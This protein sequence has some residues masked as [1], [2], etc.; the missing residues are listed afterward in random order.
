MADKLLESYNPL[1]DVHLQ[2]YFAMPHMQKHLRNLGLLESGGNKGEVY[3]RHRQMIDVMLKN[4][5]QQLVKLAELQKN[6]D[7]AE[8]VE[9]Y[10][11]IRS[12]QSPETYRRA[13][14]PSRSLSRGRRS[15]SQSARLRRSSASTEDR[16]VIAHVEKERDQEIRSEAPPRNC[17]ARLSANTGKYRH[18]HKLD[19]N[20][21]ISYKDQLR[22]Q[23]DKL[24][25]F[26]EVTFGVH[27]VAR[28]QPQSQQ[29]W[30][31]RR[32][33]LPSLADSAPAHSLHEP[34]RS[35]MKLRGRTT[36][37]TQRNL[38]ESYSSRVSCP[39]AIRKRRSS[40][41]L[42]TRLPPIAAQRA[43]KTSPAVKNNLPKLPPTTPKRLPAAPAASS[44]RGRSSSRGPIRVSSRTPSDT[45]STETKL[46]PISVVAGGAAA[47]VAAGAVV[48]AAAAAVVSPKGSEGDDDHSRGYQSA[49]PEPK[50]EE[51]EVAASE[52][53]VSPPPEREEEE[54]EEEE[55]ARG[56]RSVGEEP[57]EAPA[58]EAVPSDVDDVVKTV[59]HDEKTPSPEP[60]R[61]A[62]PE[63]EH[64][65]E[66]EEEVVQQHVAQQEAAAEEPA[67]PEPAA[68]HS[69]AEPVEEEKEVEE[70]EEEHV[71]GKRSVGEEPDPTP[72]PK[73]PSPEPAVEKEPTPEPETDHK[74]PTPE[75]EAVLQ[76]PRAEEE[77]EK[78]P[79]PVLADEKEPTPEPVVVVHHDTVDASPQPDAPVDDVI[80]TVVNDE[81]DPS[82]EPER[83]SSPV[84]VSE[85]PKAASPV[86]H[87][88]EEVAQE[89]SHEDGSPE[90]NAA[91]PAEHAQAEHVKET[92][93]QA[94]TV[95]SPE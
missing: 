63:Q 81:K 39:P 8:K 30:F 24:E 49:S 56:K 62:T 23:L 87:V 68:E 20:T 6:L 27:S 72:D 83:E 66:E 78:E 75:P 82:P 11:R 28:T 21:L 40:T 1:Y 16:D 48:A 13:A 80:E 10:R 64:L 79:S 7:A 59:V 91:S 45:S 74:S 93:S 60:E 50:R 53:T 19:D 18:L 37:P 34:L 35:I 14:K 88:E 76:M 57:E 5:E 61:E 84:A 67:T 42:T 9:I 95:D 71:R 92:L 70:E 25:R 38:G 46:P 86:E 44:T 22:R 47:A 36:A 33:S 32:R 29:S 69:S 65:Q 26:R 31:F 15:V 12:G 73:E 4:R 52:K 89:I 85:S 17:Y 77:P 90:P 41:D 94:P 54:E 58:F 2:Q 51:V 55:H 43:P 3:A